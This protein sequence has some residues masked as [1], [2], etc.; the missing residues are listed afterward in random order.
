MKLHRVF[1][2]A[3]SLFVLGACQDMTAPAPRS[4]APRKPSLSIHPSGTVLVTPSNMHGW[5]LWNDQSDT[6]CTDATVCRF[7]TGPGTPPVGNGSA[8]L[9]TPLSTDGKALL[10][11]DYAG[12]RLDAFTALSYSTYRQTADAG[13]NLAI[14]LQFTVDYD[15]TDGATGFMGRIIFEPYQTNGGSV[16]QNTWQTWDAKAGKWWGSRTT[17]TKADVS[18][19]N[20]CVQATPCTLAQLLLAFPNIGVHATLGSVVL[21]AGSGW[22]NFRGNVDNLTIGV[23][24][25]N[26]TYNF[27]QGCTYIPDYSG[28]TLVLT[29]NCTTDVS[30][31]VSDAWTL[32]LAGNAITAVDPA[33]GHFL[34]A[35]VTNVPGAT[36]ITVT[37]GTITA[38]GL[39]NVCDAG[40]DRLRGVLL[41]ESGG[42]VSN[43]TV[44]GVRQ[45]HSGCQEGNAIEARRSPFSNT[46]PKLN[47]TIS[48]NTVT[49]YQKN[50]ITCNGSL[51]CTITG[52]TTV[53]DGPITYT[54]QNGIQVAF[55]AAGIAVQNNK[56]SGNYYSPADTEACGILLFQAAGVSA[57]KNTLSA[58]EKDQCNEGKGGGKFKPVLQ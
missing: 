34:G 7:V 29:T 38:S 44:T 20:Q 1:L 4:V 40:D 32:N 54:A 46:A 25:I 28:K 17:V 6:V 26:T 33:G 36:Y 58:N 31:L 15:L 8:E 14:A 37:N 3:G 2:M 11:A 13:N 41:N 24:G 56:V 10:L 21:K 52:N 12:T 18:V 49:D 57:S 9:A 5:T 43:L 23:S 51:A 35:V 50:A 39:A 16:V 30:I 22:T 19:A 48:N 53:G 27:D 55:G 42:T 45:G 47:V